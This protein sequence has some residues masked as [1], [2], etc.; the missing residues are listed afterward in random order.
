MN[1]TLITILTTTLV[2][3]FTSCTKYNIQGSSDLQNA[4]GSMLYLKDVINDNIVNIDSCDMVHGKFSFSGALDSVRIVTLCINEQPVL[5]VVL[6]DGNILVTLNMQ[7]QTCTGTP[8][9]D[10]LNTFNLRYQQLAEQLEDLSHQQGQAIMDGKDMDT[11]N[12]Q[13]AEREE[14]LMVQE[15]KLVTTFISDNFDNCL[16]PYIF[17]IATGGYE[18][19]ILTTWIEALMTK[20]TD[21]FKNDP[22]VKEY[23]EAA[24]HNRDVMTGV[25]DPQ[26]KLPP[27]PQAK[28]PTPNELAQPQNQ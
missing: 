12:N 27:M 14:Q 1:R 11:V 9:N 20:A 26:P 24:A 4:D 28:V 23:M 10:T 3:T 17:K 8:M 18:F 15:D 22:Y 6:E 2:L 21:R 5:P 7:K 25:A 13:L 16:G 19:P